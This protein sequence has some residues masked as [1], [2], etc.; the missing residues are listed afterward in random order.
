GTQLT[1]LPEKTLQCCPNNKSPCVYIACESPPCNSSSTLRKEYFCDAVAFCA[2]H[3][4]LLLEIDTQDKLI[5][6][7]ETIGKFGHPDLGEIWVN[8]RRINGSWVHVPSNTPVPKYYWVTTPKDNECAF[9]VTY[10]RMVL[11]TAPCN[12]K[13]R[14]VICVDP[15]KSLPVC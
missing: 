2:Y 5:N 3:G 8:A 4:L 13:K 1:G 7:L 11:I 6:A 12:G 14:P 9:G 10:P 15:N